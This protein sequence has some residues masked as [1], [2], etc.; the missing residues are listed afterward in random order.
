MK[1][2]SLFIGN[3][4]ACIVENVSTRAE[5]QSLYKTYSRPSELS[6]TNHFWR[7]D[8]VSDEIK[9]H[10]K[11][12]EIPQQSLRVLTF[13]YRKPFLLQFLQSPGTC[14]IREQSNFTNLVI[15]GKSVC[16]TSILMSC[17]FTKELNREISRGIFQN[18]GV[19][20]Q[21]FPL[22]PSR[23]PFHLFCYRSNF[24]AITWLEMPAMQAKGLSESCRP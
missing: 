24:H 8:K 15:Q 2:F 22:L 6:W 10:N 3:L 13:F 1:R 23:S 12:Q 9:P 16:Y 19:C 21:A 7:F 11:K 14:S 4:A 20:G 18:H 5:E 17:Q